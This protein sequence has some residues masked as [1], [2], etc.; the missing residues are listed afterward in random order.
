MYV[1]AKS[2]TGE[3]L[4]TEGPDS[5]ALI[6][7]KAVCVGRNYLDHIQELGNAPS[8]E[9]VLFIKPASA[10]AELD[11]PLVIP[12]D[13]GACHNELELAFLIGKNLSS[14][15]ED[16]ASKAISG[17]G[18][19]LDLTLRDVQSRLKEKGQP[20]ERAKAFD[21]SC[22][23]SGFYPINYENQQF[24]FTLKVNGELRQ[25]GNS[26]L[27]LHK[28]PQLISHISKL[29]SL[30]AGDI[31]LTGTPKGVGPLHDQDKLEIKLIDYF[32]VNAQ[33]VLKNT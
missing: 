2:H 23:V 22:P 17:V 1:Q 4:F 20:W 31:V 13:F 10:I 16:E 12:N 27:M 26:D 30:Q 19:A 3:K 9:P 7:N 24:N 15:T 14:A 6:I 5:S 29:F 33:V 18:L 21:G 28:V 8:E 32:C 11:K 25:S